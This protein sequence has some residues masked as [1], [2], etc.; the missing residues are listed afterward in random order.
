MSLIENEKTS[1][2]VIAVLELVRIIAATL[3]GFLGGSV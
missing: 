3:A 2:M 1:R